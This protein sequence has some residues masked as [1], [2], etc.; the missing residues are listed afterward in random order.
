MFFFEILQV[1]RK[2]FSGHP[3]LLPSCAGKAPESK[4]S[5]LAIATEPYPGDF[6]E[7]NVRGRI[8]TEP[9]PGDFLE[10]NVRGRNETRK[11]E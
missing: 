1:L 3:D 9:Q 10:E 6:Q 5:E 4:I 11:G 7:E 8:A 2:Q